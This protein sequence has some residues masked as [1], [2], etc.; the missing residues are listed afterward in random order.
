MTRDFSHGYDANRVCRGK[1]FISMQTHRRARRVIYAE[2]EQ[3]ATDRRDDHEGRD[4][5][6]LQLKGRDAVK[7]A[8]E[9]AEA[10][11]RRDERTE[12]RLR[13]DHPRR[14]HRRA[15]RPS[16]GLAEL[17]G[18]DGE[19]GLVDLVDVDVED[20]VDADDVAVP[21]EQAEHTAKNARDERGVG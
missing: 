1:F 4:G 19:E 16:N 15:E 11:E 17:A 14:C 2:V 3:E 6:A 13:K 12:E 10:V 21:A 8:E 20:L 5:E 18:R 7:C 9:Q